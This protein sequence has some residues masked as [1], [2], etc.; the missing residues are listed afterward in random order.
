MQNCA[1]GTLLNIKGHHDTEHAAVTSWNGRGHVECRHS[2][3]LGL[4]AQAFHRKENKERKNNQR[5]HAWNTMEHHGTPWN[6]M[7]HHGTHTCITTT[8]VAVP[9]R[10]FRETL[11]AHAAQ[12]LAT[13]QP[14]NWTQFLG[15]RGWH[16]TK[17]HNLS[18]VGGSSCSVAT[19]TLQYLG[20]G[21]PKHLAQTLPPAAAR[22]GQRHPE[23]PKQEGW[24]RGHRHF[25][26]HACQNWQADAQ[27]QQ[28][29]QQP[30]LQASTPPVLLESSC[31]PYHRRGQRCS[32]EMHTQMSE[33]RCCTLHRNYACH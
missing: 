21:L 18:R 27:Q 28:Q 5:K 15:G 32:P 14:L 9:R 2:T 30:G 23:K 33:C 7:E 13:R 3:R 31:T 8:C 4:W 10:L 16:H 29:Q 11:L 1:C 12:T 6:T 19:T 22:R 24:N 26:L 20:Q 25:P 17:A